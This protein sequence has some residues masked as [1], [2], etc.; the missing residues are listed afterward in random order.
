[1]SAFTVQRDG[2]VA[3]VVFDLAGESVNKFSRAVKDEFAATMRGLWD[4]AAVAAV[5]LISGK[6]D[7]FIAGADI[8]EFVA[9]QTEDEFRKLSREGQQF[10]DTLE[11][12]KKP[13]VVAIHGACLGGGLEISLACH[14]RIATGHPKTVLG[15]PEVQLGIIPGAGGCNRLPR[16]VGLRA[17]LDMILSSRNVRPDRALRMGLVDEVVHPAIL[18][19]VAVQAARRLAG[20]ERPRRR[21]AR[22]LVGWLLDRSAPGRAL[23]IRQARAMTLQ[24]TGGH[25][26]APLAALEAVAY[27]LAHG[28]EPGL[29]HEAELFAKMAVT[30]VSRRLVEIFFATTA[31]KKHS[32]V[33]E[34]A[35]EPRPVK[36][37]AILG[38]GFMG[39]GIA[40][41]AVDQAGVSVRL[42]D[43]DLPRVGKG[44]NAAAEIIRERLKRRAITRQEAARRLALISG[45]VDYSG[46]GSAELVIEAVF[47]NLA[48]KQQVLHEV[49]RVARPDCVFASNTS[50]IPIAD[51]AEASQRPE[52]VIGM[53]FF[54]PVHRMPLLEVIPGAKTARETTV[55]AVAFGRRMGKTVIVVADRPGFFINRILAPYI[56]EAGHL[57]AEGAPIEAV[58][59]AMARW[60][61][62]VGPV[63]LLD[64]VG[65]DV[66]VKVGG[67]MHGAFGERLAPVLR[68][69]T[70]V[71][72]G[73]LGR[74]SGLGLFRYEHG[75]KAGVAED[76]YGILGLAKREG[77]GE[78]A[79]VERL[80]FAML[81]EAARAL[82]EGVIC[83]PRDGDI[84]A[85]FGIGFPPFRG[86][87]FRTLDAL[88]APQAVATLERLAT[89]HGARFA[90]ATILQD[91]ARSGGR[92][93]PVG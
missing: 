49:E 59:G 13:I 72:A 6:P 46:F 36:R 65:L 53:H 39:A 27:G 84:G 4:D 92:F 60:G 76:V 14:Y 22:G 48:I 29:A 87:P 55:T 25:Y 93:Y 58:D 83:A 7:T 56:V 35:P 78:A 88:G 1:M 11:A 85:I 24:K 30:E 26:P 28:M 43:A 90:P 71:E 8:E 37:L 3:V 38:A 67:V 15:L 75:K 91:Q 89:T 23:V 61:F 12:S 9:A 73:R 80:S 81:N 31:L 66:A 70:L 21:G 69:D 20:G 34:P 42:K 50:T 32:G 16:L 64:E 2:A 5:V 33:A 51:I 74:K 40:G 18:R 79:V 54:S 68:L 10:L 63:T 47:E 57:L 77:P 52:T 44:M 17:A 41:T 45:G 82:E 19:S 86:G 62:P